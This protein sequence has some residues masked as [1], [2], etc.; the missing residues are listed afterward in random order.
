MVASL[1][2]AQPAQFETHTVATD[3]RAGYQV[4]VADLNHDGKPDLIALA[5]SM[6]ELVWFENPSW[7]RHVLASGLSGMINCVVLEPGPQIVLASGFNMHARN[8]QGI[9]SLL[10]PDGDPRRPWKIREIDRLPASHRLR[11]AHIDGG[12]PVVINAPLTGAEAEPP[13][14]RGATP[15]V[16]YRPGE[17]KRQ[18]ISDENTGIVHCIFITDW[19]GD[20]RDDILTASFTGIHLFRFDPGPDGRPRW[21]RT[22]LAAGDPSPWPKSGSSDVAVG[23]LAGSRFLAAIEPWHGNQ[24]V[25]Y[26]LQGGQWARRVIDDSLTD[27]HA[28]VVADFDG[29]G[30]DEV[31]AGYRGAGGNVYR[32]VSADASGE[33]WTR[34]TLDA[35]MAAAACAVADLN[36]DGRPDVACIDATRLRWYENRMPAAKAK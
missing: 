1:A 12:R 23:N 21:T 22:Q 11:L 31:I 26:R 7:E 13:D 5:S 8:S 17:W 16:Y 25:I 18:T 32:Y 30:K 34:E 28:L 29:D 14:Y 33:R 9:V 3:L 10:E 4:V 36:G 2:A 15:L 27:G 6:S 20:G 19:D 24:V 35:G